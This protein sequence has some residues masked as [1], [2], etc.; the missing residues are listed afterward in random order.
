MTGPGQDPPSTAQLA[1]EAYGAEVG[2][3]N[4]RDE[5][6]P[7]WADLGAKVQ[8]GWHMAVNAVQ[9]AHYGA[10]GE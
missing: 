7:A 5:P 2:G 3:V 10:P 4:V 8:N 9:R 6:L 1:Y